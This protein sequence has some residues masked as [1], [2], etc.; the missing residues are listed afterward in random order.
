MA[1]MPDQ[2]QLENAMLQS[3]LGPASAE[4]DGTRVTQHNLKD[5]IELDRY[6]ASKQAAQKGG[7]GIILKKLSPPGAT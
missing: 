5:Q 6:L 2:S 3:A 1:D 4:T 7:L